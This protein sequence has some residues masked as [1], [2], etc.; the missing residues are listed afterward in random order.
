MKP[1][2]SKLFTTVSILTVFALCF[3]LIIIRWINIFNPDVYVIS[4]AIN[5]HITNFTISLLISVLIGYL[6][7]TYGKGFLSAL[8]VGGAV[9]LVNVIYELCLPILNTCDPVDALYGLAGVA[10]SLA[11]L[12]LLNKIGF[13][14]E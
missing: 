3:G 14:Q 6:L 11:Y 7:L 5:S 2:K 13:E 4:K 9:A 10:V 1:L 8:I 12:Y